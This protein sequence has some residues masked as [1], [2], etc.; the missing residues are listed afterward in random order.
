MKRLLWIPVVLVLFLPSV[1]QA[2]SVT[3]DFEDEGLGA[4]ND[5]FALTLTETVMIGLVPGSTPTPHDIFL[6][7]GFAQYP[8]NPTPTSD[9]ELVDLSPL[10]GGDPR[11][12]T[13]SLSFFSNTLT[14]MSKRDAVF[15]QPDIGALADHWG[16][17]RIGFDMG[18]FGGG[19]TDYWFLQSMG[20]VNAP[21]VLPGNHA[22]GTTADAESD[23][24]LDVQPMGPLGFEFSTEYHNR[25]HSIEM[26][27]LSAGHPQ[28]PNSVYLD[29]FSLTLMPLEMPA[30][31]GKRISGGSDAPDTASGGEDLST[32]PG[33]SGSGQ[34]PSTGQAVPLP[35]AVWAGMVLLAGL[36]LRRRLRRT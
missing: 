29:N 14:D 25:L 7:I 33:A 24:G 35:A 20:N 34:F 9:L 32:V 13:R 15:I 18:D 4:I 21:F 5:M 28:F 8:T 19:D 2:E 16:V 26:G 12:G 22:Q 1:A 3:F 10:L 30:T 17:G 11:W 27:Y 31:L 23:P 36:G 6:T